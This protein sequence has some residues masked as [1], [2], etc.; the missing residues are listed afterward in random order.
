VR[1]FLGHVMLS[2]DAYRV[3]V[4]GSRAESFDTTAADFVSSFRDWLTSPVYVTNPTMVVDW[5]QEDGS[6]WK[7][8]P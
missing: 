5:I 4:I 1:A 8:W 7:E 3:G 2:K 6:Q